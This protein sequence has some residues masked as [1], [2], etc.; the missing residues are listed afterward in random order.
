MVGKGSFGLVYK[1]TWREGDVAIKELIL[2]EEPHQASAAAKDLLS[3]RVE[4]IQSEFV[5][6]V[7]T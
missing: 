2:P 3:K 7:K 6:E 1:A 4:V 5:K